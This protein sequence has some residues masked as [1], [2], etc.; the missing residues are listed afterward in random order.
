METKSPLLSKTLWINAI[1]AIAAL[2]YPP[3]ADWITAN[4][5]MIVSGVSLIN[6][7]LRLVTKSGIQ[8]R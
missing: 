7:V 3:M 1:V 5:G 2:A 6:I 4:P 8:I